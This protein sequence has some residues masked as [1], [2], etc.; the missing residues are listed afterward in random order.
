MRKIYLKE[1]TKKK[2]REKLSEGETLKEISESIDCSYET[3]RRKVAEDDSIVLRKYKSDVDI[4]LFK[5]MNAE[6][7]YWLG[8][9]GADGWNG[10][11]IGISLDIIDQN[12]VELFS[13]WIGK[14]WRRRKRNRKRKNGEEFV[15]EEIQVS[16]KSAELGRLLR[17]KWGM[18]EEKSK[19]YDPIVP[20][21]K[22][23][24]FWRGMVDGDG[25]IEKTEDGK[26]VMLKLVG[27]EMVCVKF[28]EFIDGVGIRSGNIC[29]GKD[30][31]SVSTYG[32]EAGKLYRLLRKG[33]EVCLG[34]KW[35][36]GEWVT[37]LS[38]KLAKKF[39][40]ENH[41]LRTLPRGCVSY[42]WWKNGI[43]VGCAAI[44]SVSSPL[45]V[46]KGVL[47]L[48]RFCIKDAEK[49]DGSRFLSK[50]LKMEKKRNAN[51]KKIIS[52]ADSAQG[53]FGII[54]KACGGVI[55]AEGGPEIVYETPDGE[56]LTGRDN[57]II[58]RLEKKGVS[59]DE[60]IVKKSEGKKR[61]SFDMRGKNR[62]RVV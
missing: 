57:W 22:E 4:S 51:L 10:K 25:T 50:V 1:E 29:E 44:G 43:L 26:I 20:I 35:G 32:E 15:N 58:D 11:T 38:M 45:L 54:Y 30:V 49:N 9:M 36:E 5:E 56:R 34:R 14:D 52:Y 7:A 19:N 16:F 60:C 18:D 59:L 48:K 39:L 23:R 53:H 31:F 41:Y 33:G 8:L 13:E 40:E 24:H 55:E 47:E 6:A 12:H 62:S 28:K 21:G 46:E 3:L 17:E 2:I 37:K 42:G 27:T 61:F